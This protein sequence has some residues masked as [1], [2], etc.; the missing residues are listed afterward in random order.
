MRIYWTILFPLMLFVVLF[1]AQYAYTEYEK[2]FFSQSLETHNISEKV[3]INN[4]PYF[5]ELGVVR[6]GDGN[7]VKG[8]R[9]TKA[10]ILAY[11]KTAAKRNPL[12]S[13]AGTDM[14]LF[15]DAVAFLKQARTQLA[16]LQ[17]KKEGELIEDSLFPIHFL[18]S[19]NE[20]ER[21]RRAFLESG[22]D[23][24][25]R[26][27]E[28]SLKKVAEAY[29]NDADAFIETFDKIVPKDAPTFATSRRIVGRDDVRKNVEILKGRVREMYVESVRREK[30]FYHS[31]FACKSQVLQLP[32]IRI[33]ADI[34]VSE[35][36]KRN[37]R[38]VLMAQDEAGRPIE[39]GQII[40]L[41][42][43]ICINPAKTKPFFTTRLRPSSSMPTIAPVGNIR[44]IDLEKIDS[45]DFTHYYRE[46][47][48]RYVL[49]EEFNHYNCLGIDEDS[50]IIFALQAVVDYVR[51]FPLS[52]YAQ[53]ELKEALTDLEGRLW[54]DFVTETDVLLYLSHAYELVHSGVIEKEIEDEI[55]DLALQVKNRSTNSD[56]VLRNIARIELFNI[57]Q[58]EEG[59]SP[60]LVASHLLYTRSGF[61]GL[62][63]SGNESFGTG[64]DLFDLRNSLE[65]NEPYVYFLNMQDDQARLEKVTKDLK[66]YIQRNI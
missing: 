24:D 55:I 48:Y 32:D 28:S 36:D 19:V 49:A 45:I 44:F 61:A 35:E 3:Y 33:P 57:S 9:E 54:D 10:L 42:K 22:S 14:D 1:G 40:L 34:T 39:K 23:V 17:N 51:D 50:G 43:S 27:Y 13:I 31:V 62:S 12:F 8:K 52:T 37:A 29:I 20:A 53:G 4:T 41:S 65:E 26:M 58:L 38:A 6:D 21:A 60:D 5:V 59:F 64:E 18:Q 2:H 7:L 16:S 63:F 66:A 15:S 46:R 47:G 11:S 25:A 56:F 30:C